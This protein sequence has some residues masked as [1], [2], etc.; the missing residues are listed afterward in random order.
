M[1]AMAVSVATAWMTTIAVVTTI[2]VAAI[3]VT[4]VVVIAAHV[5]TQRATCT[6]TCRGADQATGSAAQTAT[7]DVTACCAQRTANGS[8]ATAM[9]VC[10]DRATTRAAQGCAD[11]GTCIAA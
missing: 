4:I 5:V 10:A 9:A 2:I 3:G 7:Y 8:F 11:G 1:L 6:A